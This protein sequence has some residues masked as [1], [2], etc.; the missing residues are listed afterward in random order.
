M[1]SNYREMNFE[2]HI[3]SHLLN[4]GY[5]KRAP[6]EYDKALCLIPDEVIQFIQATQ[7]KEFE[8]LEKQY[9]ADTSPKL[10]D[11]IAREVGKYG[12]LYVLRKGVADR[13]AKFK[14]AYFKPSS[15]MNPEHQTLYQGNRFS[16]VRQLKYSQKNENSIDTALFLNGLP[17]VTIELKNSLTGQT[18][19][20][21][22]KQYKHDRNPQGELLLQFKRCLVHFAVGN[23]Q[24]FMTTK[25]QG[26]D[27]HFLPFNKDSENPVNP[28]GHK[29]HYLW[30]DVWQADTLLELIHNYLHVQKIPEKV[31]DPETKTVTE[32][33]TEAFIFPRYHQLDV[34]RAL[35]SQVRQDGAGKNYLVQHSAG[36]GK[37]NSIAWLAHQLASF[38]QKADDTERLFDS[39]IVVTDRRLLDRQL[40]N[41]IK[42][43]EQTEGVV[44]KIDEN[45]AQLRD[46]LK[47]GKAIII[48]TLQK[49]PVISASMTDLKGKRF[50]V[51]IDEAHSSQSGESA[52]HLKK[53][54]AVNLEQA[55][56][57]DHD[58]F[59]LEDEI[60]KE[61][62][63]RG[64]QNHISYFAFTATPKNKT[65][66]L[67]GRK[68]EEGKPVAHHVYSMRQA[69]EENFILD[70]LKNYTTFKRYFKLIKTIPTDD[71]YE[72]KK[73]IRLLTS[74]V[75]L[76]PHAIE[77]KTR[78]M[79]DHFM[80]KTVNTIQGKGRAMVVTRSR[81]H[82]VKFYLAFRKVMEEKRLP[83]KALVAF[84]GEVTDPETHEKY[85]ENSL[86]R[87]PP[88]VA[89]ED[90]YKMP[91]YRIL[92]VANK[93]QTGFDEP[94]MH[95]MYVDKKLDGVQAVQTLSRLN[96][97]PKGKEMVFVLDFVNEAED[98]QA[99]FQ[100][101]FQTTLLEEETDPNKLYD[102]QTELQ[103]FE[104]FTKADVEEFA[105]V[106]YTL[107]I[108]LEKLQPVLDRVVHI[109]NGKPEEERED[110]RAT[111]QKFI[112]LYGFVSQII[113]FE[114]PDLEKLYVF[115][116]ALNRK[117]PRRI[118]RLPYEIRDAVDLDSFRLQKTF[119]DSIE[120]EKKDGTVEGM[121]DGGTGGA[122][123]EKD[124]LS[125]IIETLNTTYGINL[126][127]EDKVDIQT[128]RTK[129]E[130]DET[131]QA[132]FTA[133][134]TRADKV[135][136]FNEV[137][138]RLLLEFVH[139]KLELY[140]KLTEPK[141]N[142]MFKRQWFEKFVQEFGKT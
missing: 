44:K 2:E 47:A 76:T 121:G 51:I 86:N 112:R 108:P 80:E 128:I 32:K 93:Y 27:T 131:L 87:L 17:I 81:L 105:E 142:E 77:Q 102:Q 48:T 70:V 34:V 134:N 61:I 53:T 45:S 127:D 11:R 66:E 67:F 20:D 65:L 72:K 98:I 7:P 84:S 114:D 37:S 15:G 83:F 96:R 78:I 120:L 6:E 62:R 21:A 91:D 106:F 13:G 12:V 9:G 104:V 90:A 115:A 41:T 99:A 25:L 94:L 88:K 50:A 39:I 135:Y 3:E 75:D 33:E 26:G 73:A 36:S 137:L 139:T 60:L 74:D 129:L 123:E 138:D 56:A 97:K 49:F 19:D 101:Y 132:V 40:Q 107:N 68:N 100:P 85:T 55:E 31:Y 54:L 22:I 29:T 8:K 1:A 35:L 111:I 117:L 125:H 46:A 141:V 119:E 69:I 30:E 63:T 38:Y 23:E 130:A 57:E 110:F 92:V 28:N 10:L 133:D 24:A 59:D 43:F 136:K 64:K 71:E 52:K 95:T 103:A 118:T 58:D 126:S 116:K 79:L 42:Q 109:W 122:D 113:T 5:R 124:L 18:V 140:K 82:A 14:L 16:V 89:I 4:S